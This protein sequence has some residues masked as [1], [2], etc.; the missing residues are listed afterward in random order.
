MNNTYWVGKNGPELVRDLKI[1][2]LIEIF[3]K[4]RPSFN[5]N[6]F[7]KKQ[8]RAK[9][10]RHITGKIQDNTGFSYDDEYRF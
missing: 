1:D 9:L 7:S 4:I 3:K 8:L 10:E 6:G 5:P 2:R